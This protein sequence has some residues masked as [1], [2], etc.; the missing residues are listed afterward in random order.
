M[1]KSLVPDYP[2]SSDSEPEETQP[3]ANKKRTILLPELK[4]SSKRQKVAPEAAPVA[5]PTVAKGLFGMLPKPKNVKKVS[6][7]APDTTKKPERPINVHKQ[8]EEDIS[9]FSFAEPS[10]PSTSYNDEK[11]E[12]KGPK[13]TV[14]SASSAYAYN[15]IAQY[16]YTSQVTEETTK[17]NDI[18][19][20]K[21]LSS[22]V[23]ARGNMNFVDINQKDIIGEQWE[24]E[25]LKMHNPLPVNA[26]DFQVKK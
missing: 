17:V 7:I 26:N 23:G 4:A 9:F 8:Q 16:E 11:P 1:K 19:A 12:V 2:S 6:S 15:P 25:Q 22:K 3:A 24:R 20:L 18:D 14:Q 13:P 5:S 10:S 21:T